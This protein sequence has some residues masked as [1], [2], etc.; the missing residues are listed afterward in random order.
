MWI[1][2][3][4]R[5]LPVFVLDM[6]NASVDGSEQGQSSSLAIMVRFVHSLCAIENR[7]LQDDEEGKG[8]NRRGVRIEDKQIRSFARSNRNLPSSFVLRKSIN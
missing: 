5:G 1:L 4:T 7:T 8:R 6:S 3:Q 2:S